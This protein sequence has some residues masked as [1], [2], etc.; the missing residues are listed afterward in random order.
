[1][2]RSWAPGSTII[3]PKWYTK[4]CC[5]TANYLQWP[6]HSLPRDDDDDTAQGAE[7]MPVTSPGESPKFRSVQRSVL[8]KLAHERTPLIPAGLEDTISTD[9]EYTE[10]IKPI[11]GHVS[12]S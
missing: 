10:T 11:K 3:W 7:Q 5:C 8:M 2:Y 9:E 12:Y 6:N 1:M 4:L